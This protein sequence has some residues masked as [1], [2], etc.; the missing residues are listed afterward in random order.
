MAV[1]LHAINELKKKAVL[2]KTGI[3]TEIIVQIPYEI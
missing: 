3:V 2:T 1:M